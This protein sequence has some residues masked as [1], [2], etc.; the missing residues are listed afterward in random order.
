MMNY[1]PQPSFRNLILITMI[2]LTFMLSSCMKKEKYPDT[3][4]IS[5]QGFSTEFDS[6]LYAKRGILTI[7]FK[8]GNGD[9]GLRPDQTSPLYDTAGNYY[10][11]Y[12]IDYYE[13]QNGRFVKIELE[14]SYNARIPYLTPNDPD[15]PIKGVIVDTLLLNPMPVFDTVKF[16]FYIY[17]RALNKS[18]V[19]STPPIILRRQ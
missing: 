16:K 18:N 8:D 10:Y 3:P 6:G 19:D 15:K 5:F 9:I 12:V 14:P 17:D 11:N 7:S 4:Q 13:L 2:G 1:Q